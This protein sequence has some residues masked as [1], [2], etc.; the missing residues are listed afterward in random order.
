[1][2]PS[3]G[4]LSAVSPMS[5][6][7]CQVGEGQEFE[8]SFESEQALGPR[9]RT[10]VVSGHQISVVV[11]GW[12]EVSP[13]TIDKVG[14]FF[15]P[16]LPLCTNWSLNERENKREN[17]PA[18][19]PPMRVVFEVTIKGSALKLVTVRSALMVENKLSQSV[20][21]RLENKIQSL[22][23][24]AK[25]FRQIKILPQQRIPVPLHYIWADFTARPIDSKAPQTWN[26]SDQGTYNI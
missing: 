5:D 24:E 11:E 14:T 15:R 8:F 23:P 10:S 16:A 4:S 25:K 6:S 26:F 12:Q 19:L 13:V 17:N 22:S 7:W 9:G 21:L 1:M 20:E 2:A 18:T 3:G